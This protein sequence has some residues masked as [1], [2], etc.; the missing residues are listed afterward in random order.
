NDNVVLAAE[1]AAGLAT[2]PVHVVPT[3]SIQGGL[4]ALVPFDPGRSAEENVAEMAEAAARVATGAVTRAS[5]EVRLNGRRVDA[6]DYLGLVDGEPFSGGDDFDAV[7]GA[8]LERL[9]AQPRDVLTLLVG[10]EEP[11]LERLLATLA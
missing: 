9:L 5:R 11:G 4:A 1:Q 6:G 7:A 3:T 10:D 8:V 2:K